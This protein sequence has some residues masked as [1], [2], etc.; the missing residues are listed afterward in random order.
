MDLQIFGWYLTV[1]LLKIDL[2]KSMG[3]KILISFLMK[4][5]IWVS[6]Y[7]IRIHTVVDKPMSIELNVNTNVKDFGVSVIKFN[8]ELNK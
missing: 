6:L 1:E 5:F 3:G 4:H 8:T 7:P 2:Q